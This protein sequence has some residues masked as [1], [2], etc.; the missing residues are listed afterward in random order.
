MKPKFIQEFLRFTSQARNYQG[1][2]AKNQEI[3]LK[4]LK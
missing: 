1:N 3:F 4:V 2:K